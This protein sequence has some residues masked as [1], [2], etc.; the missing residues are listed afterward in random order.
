MLTKVSSIVG[1]SATSKIC[2]ISFIS[3]KHRLLPVSLFILGSKKFL[4][5]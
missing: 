1:T 2:D 3:R 4:Y 5:V